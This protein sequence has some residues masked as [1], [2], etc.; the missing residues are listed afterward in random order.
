[1]NKEIK[2]YK[3]K[4]L[5]S[6]PLADSVYWVKASPS[7]EVS[8]YIT[9][10]QGVPY[11]LK[12]I[13]GSGGIQ[14]ITNTDGNIS[15]T[16]SGNIIINISPSLLSVINS[17]LQSGDNI[18]EL[19]ND[20]GYLTSFTETDPVFQASE[21]SLFVSGD[22]ANLDNQSGVNSG[23]ETT[24]SIQTK[25]PLKT[26]NGE[27][28]EGSG[29]I[30]VTGSNITNTSEL[31]NDGSDGTST[32]VENNELGATAFS[33][34]YNDLDNLPV[35]STLLKEEFVFSGSQTFTLTNNYAQV[36]SVEV[37]GQGALS[38]SQYTLVAP[39]QITINDT[40]DTGDYVVIIYSDAS[41]GVVP[42]Y[43]Q[44]QTD[45]GFIAT[46][47]NFVYVRDANDFPSAVSGIRT[48]LPDVTYFIANNIDLNGDRLVGSSNT[49]IIGGSSENST[50]TS[51]GLGVS[52]PLYYSIYTT[53]IR[54]ISFKDVHTA[55]EFDGTTNPNDMALDWT[56]VNFVNVPNIG[57]IKKASNFIFDKGAF[58][59]SKEMSFDGTIGTVGFGNSLFSGDGLLGDILKIESTC[60]IT[61]RFRIVYSSIIAFG[62]T[63]GINVSTSA[64]IPNEGYILDTIN[65][66]GG[67]TYLV[68]VIDNGDNKTLFNNCRGIIN[69]NP[70]SQYY[71]NGNLTTTT[72]SSTGVA[73]K[74]SGTTSSSL[75]T[76]KFTN[77]NNRATY[78]GAI[79]QIFKVVATLSLESGNNNQIGCYIAKNGTILPESEVYGTTNGV[80]RA[81]N[82][83]IQT[84]VN[85][86]TNDYIEI[87]VENETVTNNILVTDLNVIVD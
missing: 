57:L 78:N 70:N 16:G 42:Y 13:S 71:M 74:V 39:N 11:P 36:Y 24:L 18:S 5:P 62:S 40:L 8:G 12:D 20:A 54:H 31:I 85:L 45:V 49:T 75:T 4:Q 34:D 2:H 25:R 28:L 44:A 68:G 66:S 80:G 43:T 55:I 65:F 9:D 26:I 87:F 60:T 22:K 50:L 32:Y 59:N 37:Q 29:N 17:A 86:S 35:V 7:S 6:R 53:P 58:L 41:A 76:Q 81:E 77:T 15:I 48:L 73:V 64:T 79:S 82:I 63:D 52:I 14:T 38:T 46:V 83:V 10:L 21:A 3:V 51:T 67:S 23:D 56:G 69:T 84:K 33:N 1:M 72:I 47:P 61:R 19:V 27:S 30:S